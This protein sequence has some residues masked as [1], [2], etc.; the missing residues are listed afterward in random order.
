MSVGNDHENQNYSKGIDYSQLQLPQNHTL[1][2]L[3]IQYLSYRVY[4]NS[5]HLKQNFITGPRIL[6]CQKSKA[7]LFNSLIPG[8][9]HSEHIFSPG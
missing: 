1:K 5:S 6:P 7:V 9:D 4:H 2:H 3:K 8:Y